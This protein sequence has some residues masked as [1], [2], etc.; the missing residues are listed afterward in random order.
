MDVC[1]CAAR[2]RDVEPSSGGSLLGVV[3]LAL[4]L[5]LNS[6]RSAVANAAN[7]LLSSGEIHKSFSFFV[8]VLKILSLAL[9]VA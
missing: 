3:E 7:F 9:L 6:C 2:T 8:S 1:T 5:E 4:I